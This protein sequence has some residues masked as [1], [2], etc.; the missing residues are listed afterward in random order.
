MSHARRELMAADT[1]A[2]IR[3]AAAFVDWVLPQPAL[4]GETQWSS[5]AST[6][7]S[8]GASC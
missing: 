3:A 1:T 8:R 4:K 5:G 7:R 6:A 2:T